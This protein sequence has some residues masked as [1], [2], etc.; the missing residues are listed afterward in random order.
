MAAQIC[1]KYLRFKFRHSSVSSGFKPT[2][3]DD[4]TDLMQV[5]AGTG[6]CRTIQPDPSGYDKFGRYQRVPLVAIDDLQGFSQIE[7]IITPVVVVSIKK[8]LTAT[9]NIRFL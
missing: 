4:I 1:S 6:G 7:N 9:W 5:Y 2:N 3:F 8:E